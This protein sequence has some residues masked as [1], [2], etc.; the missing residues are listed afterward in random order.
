MFL[1]QELALADAHAVLAAARATQCQGSRDDLAVE[2]PG[3][4]QAVRLGRHQDQ[5]VEVAVADMADD[6]RCQAGCRD[7]LLSAEDRLAQHRNRHHAI[8]DHTAMAGFQRQRGPIRIV[9]R[10]PQFVALG[11][12]GGPT[13]TLAIAPHGELLGLLCSF[14][15]RSGGAVKLEKHRRHGFQP[16]QLGVGD[17]GGG[18]HVVQQLHSGD[19]DAGLHDGNHRFHGIGQADK[20]AGG[21]RDRFGDRM[22]PQLDFGD[23]A[24]RA[25]R[26]HEQPRQV[27][28]GGG[29]AHPAAGV[30]D[31]AVGQ[32]DGEAHHIIPHR[33]VAHRVGAGS[34]RRRHAADGADLGAGIDREEQALV[35]QVDIQLLLRDAS[36][37][38][39]IHVLLADRQHRGH[40]AQVDGDTATDRRHM[41]LQRRPGAERH[42]RD[43]M[44]M[45]KPQ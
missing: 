45:A 4:G 3:T 40:A 2:L 30:D 22:Q 24:Q 16:L 15:D 31:A 32:C 29:F 44:R 8:G 20:L 26:P 23:D 38:A 12:V 18:L 28:A 9:P 5:R 17:A 7:V 39:T 27:V 11:G 36:L 21:G 33:A 6:G 14:L 34:P 35:T 41:P 43:A 25:L 13:E 10:L 37:N 19:R 1:F 42:H